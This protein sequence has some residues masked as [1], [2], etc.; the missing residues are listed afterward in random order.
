MPYIR[1][2]QH[3][4]QGN[5]QQRSQASIKMK[6]IRDGNHQSFRNFHMTHIPQ[7]SHYTHTVYC[8]VVLFRLIH[9]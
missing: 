5:L 4:L 7:F 2:L 6:N 9:D 1:L 3:S 8:R